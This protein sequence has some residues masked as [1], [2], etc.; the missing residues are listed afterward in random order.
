MYLFFDLLFVFPQLG[1][2][3]LINTTNNLCQSLAHAVKTDVFEELYKKRP[4]KNATV[5]PNRSIPIAISSNLKTSPAS[6][7]PISRNTSNIQNTVKIPISNPSP[8]TPEYKPITINQRQQRSPQLTLKIKYPYAA[9]KKQENSS[10]KPREYLFGT[11][12]PIS[13]E[14]VQ[15]K[16]NE[17]RFKTITLKDVRRSFREKYLNNEKAEE[18]KHQPLWFVDVKGNGDYMR[19]GPNIADRRSQTRSVHDRPSIDRETFRG[20]RSR[21]DSFR[22]NESEQWRSPSVVVLNRAQSPP[23]CFDEG[24]KMRSSSINVINGNSY[25]T[26]KKNEPRFTPVEHEQD[27]WKSSPNIT[28]PPKEED[29]FGASPHSSNTYRVRRKENQFEISPQSSIIYSSLDPKPVVSISRKNT[30]KV[31]RDDV[32]L[33]LEH[34]KTGSTSLKRRDTFVL[35]ILPTPPISETKRGYFLNRYRR[36]IEPEPEPLVTDRHQKVIPI[37][38]AMPYNHQDDEPQ[39]I[40]ASDRRRRFASSHKSM[41]E[42]PNVRDE[43]P[44]LYASTTYIR[45]DSQRQKSPRRNSPEPRSPTAPSKKPFRSRSTMLQIG[46]TRKKS[47]ES[48]KISFESLRKPTSPKRDPGQTNLGFDRFYDPN[49]YVPKNQNLFGPL[50]TAQLRNVNVIVQPKVSDRS[51]WLYSKSPK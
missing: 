1:S 29:T 4:A 43:S 25:A 6:R 26:Y 27:V 10:P 3:C 24:T 5:K 20:D 16:E 32:P 21:S 40:S 38:V 12:S 11:A 48:V 47:V 23:E 31:V 2:Y 19:S 30:F 22:S 14:K 45:P 42:E 46:E 15:N 36:L 28:L 39:S 37:G 8:V 44:P 41:Q 17:D 49:Y 13:K 34:A 18:K 35:D 51:S 50:A 7:L 33:P 9:V